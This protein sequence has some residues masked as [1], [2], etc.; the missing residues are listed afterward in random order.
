MGPPLQIYPLITSDFKLARDLFIYLCKEKA[1]LCLYRVVS[2][3]QNRDDDDE[4]DSSGS[5][6]MMQARADDHG[7]EVTTNTNDDLMEY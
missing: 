5:L 6:A 2:M 3:E 4:D 7:D 1:M